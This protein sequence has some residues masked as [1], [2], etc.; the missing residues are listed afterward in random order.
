MRDP[1]KVMQ[2]HYDMQT[3]S[4]VGNPP[5][6]QKCTCCAVRRSMGQFTLASTMCRQCVRRAPR[7]AA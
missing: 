1:G 2:D 6:L 3:L 7:L 4:P 5:K